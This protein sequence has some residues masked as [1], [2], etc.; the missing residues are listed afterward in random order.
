M[1][2][3]SL[4]RLWRGGDEG[5]DYVRAASD[6]RGSREYRQHFDSGRTVTGNALSHFEPVWDPRLST[7]LALVRATGAA[8]SSASAVGEL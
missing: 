8:A 2:R 1:S 3:R 7:L 6:I 4:T 5:D